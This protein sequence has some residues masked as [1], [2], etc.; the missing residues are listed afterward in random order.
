VDDFLD[1]MVGKSASE[2]PPEASYRIVVGERSI[3]PIEH[4]L[5]ERLTIEVSRLG[6]ELPTIFI[7]TDGNL[8]KPGDGKPDPWCAYFD[9]R[10]PAPWEA[11]ELMKDV[12]ALLASHPV[13]IVGH[14][15][16]LIARELGPRATKEQYIQQCEKEGVTP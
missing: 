1:D 10:T 9:G 15:R 7:D 5:K 3:N 4:E 6:A 2:A 16:I 13:V 14:H 11:A 8:E 12:T